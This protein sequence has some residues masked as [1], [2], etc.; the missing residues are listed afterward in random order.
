VDDLT[1]EDVVALGL[2]AD[3]FLLLPLKG[4]LASEIKRL[5]TV[6]TV[7]KT[8]NS[9][10]RIHDLPDACSQVKIFLKLF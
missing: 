7:W 4:F 10:V 3:E 1:L 8:L 5:V 9:I 2:A 6:E